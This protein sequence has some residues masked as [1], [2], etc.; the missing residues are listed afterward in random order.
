MPSALSAARWP[1]GAKQQQGTEPSP[2]GQGQRHALLRVPGSAG[3]EAWAWVAQGPA[4]PSSVAGGS[5]A[6][7]SGCPHWGRGAVGFSL[8]TD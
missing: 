8:L 2:E 1:V 5:T 4:R 7:G 3:K 6:L